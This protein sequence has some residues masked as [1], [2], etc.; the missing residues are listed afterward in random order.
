MKVINL[1][2]APSSGKTTTLLGLG[3]LMKINKHKVEP[4]HEYAKDLVFEKNALTLR[5]QVAVLGEQFRRLERLESDSELVWSVTD[6]PLPLMSIYRPEEYF[7]SFD[8]LVLELYQKNENYNFFL[9]NTGGF[10][11]MGR[12]H[13]EEKSKTIGNQMLSFLERH[14]LPFVVVDTNPM[15]PVEIYKSI[16]PNEAF[17]H[18]FFPK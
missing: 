5:N 4:A 9:Q 1:W 12:V 11:T 2:G 18:G 3:Y 14:H 13:D 15:S 17:D 7:E 16:F 6:C 10:E 8:K